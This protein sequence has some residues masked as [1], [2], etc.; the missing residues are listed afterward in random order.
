MKTYNT[1]Q[2]AKIN[3]P[4]GG[5]AVNASGDIFTSTDDLKL[6]DAFAFDVC[7]PADHC[8]TVERFLADGHKFTEGDLILGT[9][10]NLVTVGLEYT[11]GI[12][13][14]ES[15]RDFERYTLRAAALEDQMN[16]DK[17]ETQPE[18]QEEVSAFSGE[19]EW[20]SGD[21][22]VVINDNDRYFVYDEHKKHLGSVGI[23]RSLFKTK[24]GTEMAAVQA[25][26]GDCICWRV[27]MLSKP[28]TPQQREDRE[29]LEAAYELYCH[30]HKAVYPNLKMRT[31]HEF[32]NDSQ[33]RD[34]YLAIVDK[35]NYR[36]GVK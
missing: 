23:I 28:E 35:T 33:I 26:N 7:N 36:K 21:E 16:I 24:N 12:A 34:G 31:K 15:M 25:E 27:V 3:N 19:V 5:I 14:M 22:C 2:E 1:Y 11:I 8:M 9:N 32:D 18:H 4:E 30:K 29:R 20:K 17:V 10:N 6:S 13:N